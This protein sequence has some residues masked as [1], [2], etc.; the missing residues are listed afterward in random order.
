MDTVTFQTEKRGANETRTRYRR[1]SK[2]SRSGTYSYLFTRVEV[3]TCATSVTRRCARVD[4]T[5][6]EITTIA[7]RPTYEYVML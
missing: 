6:A 4:E 1:F 3:I 2:V 5:F 7:L